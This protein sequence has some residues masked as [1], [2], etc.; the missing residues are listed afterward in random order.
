[1]NQLKQQIIKNFRLGGLTIRQEAVQKLEAVLSREVPA[2][3]YEDILRKLVAHIDKD[4]I[5]MCVVG[6]ETVEAL[7]QDLGQD[8]DEVVG[9]HKFQFLGAFA[10]PRFQFDE[11]Q[12][13]FVGAGGSQA[14]SVLAPLASLPL[15]FLQRYAAIRQRVSRHPLFRAPLLLGDG[16]GGRGG[17]GLEDDGAAGEAARQAL[18]SLEALRGAGPGPKWV[19]AML[20][21]APGDDVFLEDPTARVAVDLSEADFTS[22][23]FSPGCFVI[24]EG[25]FA[26]GRFFVSNI[27]FPPAEDRRATL[28]QFP[29]TNLSGLAPP[30]K[31]RELLEAYERSAEAEASSFIVL[32][33]VWLDLPETFQ[34][35]RVLFSGFSQASLLEDD[36]NYSSS[37]TSSTSHSSHSSSSSTSNHITPPEMFVLMGNFTKI[38]FVGQIGSDAISRYKSLMDKLAALIAS[39][40]VLAQKSRFVLI[41]GP[42]DP[43]S[44]YGTLP[45]H[46][47]P[48][49]LTQS[50]S[51]RL[52]H[53][54]SLSNPARVRYCTQSMVFFRGDLVNKLRRTAVRA[55]SLERNTLY[56]H[57]VKTV[58]DQGHL[59]PFTPSAQ[60][61]FWDF[62]Q[63]LS[64]Y[65]VPDVLVLADRYTAYETIY[66]DCVV[67]NPS[68]FC[69][70]LGFMAYFPSDR[71]PKP[72]SLP[73]INTL[74]NPSLINP[75]SSSSSISSTTSSSSSSSN[76]KKR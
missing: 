55:P 30:A 56:E 45:R 8:E 18:S 12:K 1:M 59:S 10:G 22:G 60:P 32:S 26:D 34:A 11:A 44:C 68:T 71:L 76:K 61:V 46:A 23:C 25:C 49:F 36:Q 7:L 3:E 28:Q 47:L 58:I 6:V 65:P 21:H 51:D 53:F 31:Y 52:A 64:L 50:L 2:C 57:A 48:G 17:R 74:R 15:V 14:G 37:S 13:R 69:S 42:D 29:S 41:P 75:S 4:G 35:L 72:C 39:F 9:L 5:A 19:L 20:V 24:A 54:V 27:G 16:P 70:D 40:P 73:P 67:F 62:D 38:P 66:E 33:D 43:G 63:A